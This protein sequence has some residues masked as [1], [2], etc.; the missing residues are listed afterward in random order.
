[1][2]KVMKRKKIFT[3]GLNADMGIRIDQGGETISVVD[4]RGRV[5]DG[6]RMLAVMTSLVLRQNRG[7]VVAAPV[8]APSALQHI[9]KRYEGTIQHTKVLRHA[10]MSAAGRDG[11]VLAGDGQGGFIFPS[12]HPVGR[13]SC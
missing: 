3:A 11:V 8:T 4:D 6:T 13:A 9:A 1:M 5:L 7:A 2:K 10:M 12:L